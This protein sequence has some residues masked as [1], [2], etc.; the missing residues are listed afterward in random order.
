MP[1]SIVKNEHRIQLMIDQN[2]KL[3][4]QKYQDELKK[5][6]NVSVQRWMNTV[7]SLT[8]KTSYTCTP[9]VYT[10]MYSLY[11]CIIHVRVNIIFQYIHVCC[12]RDSTPNRDIF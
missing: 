1:C 10:I 12:W 8:L 6:I 5:T 9:V 4:D 7:K 11:I 3:C 2:H